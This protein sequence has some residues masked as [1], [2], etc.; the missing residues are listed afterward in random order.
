MRDLSE[1]TISILLALAALVITYSLFG[2][3]LTNQVTHSF[4]RVQVEAQR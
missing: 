4:D 3:W 2:S 1:T